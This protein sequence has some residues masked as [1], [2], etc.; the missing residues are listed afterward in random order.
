MAGA[1][2]AAP[3]LWPALPAGLAPR[4]PPPEWLP[5]PATSES[6]AGLKPSMTG[7][8]GRGGSSQ[9]GSRPLPESLATVAGRYYLVRAQHHSAG[10]YAE[11]AQSLIVVSVERFS[12]A[13]IGSV[14]IDPARD[15]LGEVAR[16][17]RPTL[18]FE[19]GRAG[20]TTTGVLRWPFAWPRALE[21]RRLQAELGI[22]HDAERRNSATWR[23]ACCKSLVLTQR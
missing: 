12:L 17:L 22:D 15:R 6:P 1:S 3:R 11:K 9:G 10:N 8:P 5:D 23:T 7:I 2:Q 16:R 20:Q 19:T 14:S 4:S 13:S 21:G 18:A